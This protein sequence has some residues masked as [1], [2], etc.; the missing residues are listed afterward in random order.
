VTFKEIST[1][2]KTWALIIILIK[3]EVVEVL[4][5]LGLALKILKLKK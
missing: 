3:E 4:C 5:V 2:S 1:T